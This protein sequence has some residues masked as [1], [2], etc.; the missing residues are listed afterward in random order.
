MI[1][2]AYILIAIACGLTYPFARGIMIEQEPTGFVTTSNF[3]LNYLL[4]FVMAGAVSPWLSTKLLFLRRFKKATASG[5][6]M[7]TLVC[8][9][10][11]VLTVA[12]MSMQWSK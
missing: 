2:V 4:L 9:L 10:L 12:G 6:V 7:V 11:V 1:K 5:V 8:T 3:T